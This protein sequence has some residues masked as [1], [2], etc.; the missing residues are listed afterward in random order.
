MLLTVCFKDFNNDT[1]VVYLADM[2]R[3]DPTPT[4]EKVRLL[5]ERWT[6]PSHPR[7]STSFSLLVLVREWMRV[8]AHPLT[9]L[10]PPLLELPT[11][12]VPLPACIHCPR[13]RVQS[14]PRQPAVR[15]PVVLRLPEGGAFPHAVR[16]DPSEAS[17]GLKLLSTCLFGSICDVPREDRDHWHNHRSGSR[18]QEIWPWSAG[19]L[20]GR[21]RFSEGLFS[22]TLS[23]P[24]FVW[25]HLRR[26][27]R[28]P[29]EKL[30]PQT[31][32]LPHLPACRWGTGCARKR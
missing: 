4:M 27:S 10:N 7:F 23:H 3:E 31:F 6:L 25:Q 28:F 18:P 21:D 2:L 20:R 9:R 12:Q 19:A 5:Q 15:G 32:S 8:S 24:L 29:A 11:D 26:F 13:A 1:G 16:L 22:P 30:L 17:C 14:R